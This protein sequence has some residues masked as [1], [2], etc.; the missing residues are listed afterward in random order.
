MDGKWCS[1]YITEYYVT[2]IITATFYRSAVVPNAMNAFK[3]S[4]CW[5]LKQ[6]V[7]TDADF[8]SN[9]VSVRKINGVAIFSQRRSLRL[10]KTTL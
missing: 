5:P 8:A 6:F 7:F 3:S 4:A 9:N 1:I 2:D 10:S